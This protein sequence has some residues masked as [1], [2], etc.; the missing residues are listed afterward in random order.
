M[1]PTAS[2]VAPGIAI[3]AVTYGLARFAY[4]LFLPEI[5]ADVGFDSATAGA[6]GG[7]AYAG[8][9]VAIVASTILVE[10][11]G[12]RRVAIATGLVAA[13]GMGLM[14]GS[15]AP[16]MLA[17]GVLLAGTSTGLSSPPMTDAVSRA[18]P[19]PQQPRANSLI[20][21]GTSLGVVLAGPIA[22]AAT[23][24]WREAYLLFT[25][26]ALAATVW[27]AIGLPRDGAAHR[28]AAGAGLPAGRRLRRTDARPVLIAAAGMGFASAAY[29]TFAGDVMVTLGGLPRSLPGVAWVV[30][31]GAGLLGGAAGDLIRRYGITA[32]HRGW[33]L[34]LIGA[35]LALVLL[36]GQPAAVLLSA[37]LFGVA[38]MML[39]G[40]YLVW[41]VRVYSDRPAVGVGL[42]FLTIALGQGIGAPIAGSAIEL[43]GHPAT[44][45]AFAA[46]A[47]LSML[48]ACRTQPAPS[49]AVVPAHAA[50]AGGGGD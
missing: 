19:E 30:I 10:R 37:G 11:L 6:I 42:P 12:A 15:A 4:G 41:G 33:L 39:T 20:N 44:F 9:A 13:L 24:Q 3:I 5:R 7:M 40:I 38:Y 49:P 43:A 14:A 8:Y 31:G 16:W 18:V 23:G 47:A 26:I 48:P 35:S 1:R 17:G 21:A 22:L 50:G 29:W 25:A 28:T 36:P 2:V 32:V 27:L 45:A 46:V 34:A